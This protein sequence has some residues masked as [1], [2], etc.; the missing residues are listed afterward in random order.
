MNINRTRLKMALTIALLVTSLALFA[1]ETAHGQLGGLGGHTFSTDSKIIEKG[2]TARLEVANTST[3]SLVVWLLFRDSADKVLVKKRVT[4]KSGA[5]EA[6]KYSFTGPNNPL[7]DGQMEVRA[8]VAPSQPKL[9]DSLKPTLVILGANG[10]A[11][12][13]IGPEGFAELRPGNDPKPKP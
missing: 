1:M 10:Q 4:I 12:L 13:Q 7:K 3:K 11:V 8:Q 9:M 2:Q 5:T 6:L